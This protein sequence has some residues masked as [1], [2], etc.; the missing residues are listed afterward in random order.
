MGS[1]QHRGGSGSSS[2]ARVIRIS[3]PHTSHR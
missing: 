3:E 2:G 1:M